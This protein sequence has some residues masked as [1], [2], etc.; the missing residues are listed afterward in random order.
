M[1]VLQERVAAVLQS[2]NRDQF[3]ENLQVVE[4]YLQRQFNRGNTRL[5]YPQYTNQEPLPEYQQI[6]YRNY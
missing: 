1:T 5:T 2:S 6:Q 3:L 4:E